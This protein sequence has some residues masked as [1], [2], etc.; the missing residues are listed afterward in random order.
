MQ[1][2]RRKNQSKEIESPENELTHGQDILELHNIALQTEPEPNILTAPDVKAV[3]F[4]TSTPE[5]YFFDDVDTWH[6]Q[7]LKA[8]AWYTKKLHQRDL[9]VYNLATEIDKTLTDLTN[10][11]YELE[12]VRGRG[13][14]LVGDSGE[15]LSA[16]SDAAKV[17]ELTAKIEELEQSIFEDRASANDKI[18][19]LEQ[20]LREA[21]QH[22]SSDDSGLS[23]EEVQQFADLREWATQAE[24]AFNELETRHDSQ[25]LELQELRET[26]KKQKDYIVELQA[27]IENLEESI[28]ASEEDSEI[29]E[30][31]AEGSSFAGKSFILDEDQ[32][33]EVEVPSPQTS[34][35][36]A[37]IEDE[38]EE[39]ED[40]SYDEDEVTPEATAEL[41]DLYSS[42]LPPGVTLP[43]LGTESVRRNQGKIRP[44]TPF[45]TISTEEEL[46]KSL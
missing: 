18:R 37:F 31:E 20:S 16:D 32:E 8:I 12:L 26:E 46:D 7:V 28:D 27:Y 21:E 35:N 10:K 25:T 38:D 3:Q 39:V 14:V 17:V 19:L 33:E 9:D 34:Q 4:R 30:D 15:Y 23:D 45:V 24:I 11:K 6:A 1:A 36:F 22:D 5:G 2:I 41:N 13:Q 44:D 29:N 43:P 42:E 40:E